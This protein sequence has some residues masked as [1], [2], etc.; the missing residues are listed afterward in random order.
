[1]I[2]LGFVGAMA[3]GMSSPSQAQGFYVEGPG[4]TFGIGQPWPHDR[5]YRLY[6]RSGYYDSP[7]YYYR[8]DRAYS[9]DRSYRRNRDWD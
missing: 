3:L 5:D 9:R 7:G 6:D 4:V 2:A 1:M 8:Y